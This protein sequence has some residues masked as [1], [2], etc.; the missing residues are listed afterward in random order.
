[1]SGRR[2]S[3]SAVAFTVL[4]VGVLLL[5]VMFAAR[6]GPH[7]IFAGP[8]RDPHFAPITVSISPRFGGGPAGRFHQGPI[9]HSAF[10]TAVGWVV[11]LAILAC[12]L[13]VGYRGVRRLLE[14]LHDLRHRQRLTPAPDPDF[15]VLD[16]PDA[17]VTEMRKDADE[18]FE[19]LLDGAPRNAIVACWDRFEEQAERTGQSRLEWETSSEF[20]LR[21]LDH[22]AADDAAVAQLERLY[23]EA[24]FSEHEIG[25]DQRLAAVEAL[26]RI[27]ASL[28]IGVRAR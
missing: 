22:V 1:M 7:R 9:H 3:V 8:L 11:R 18:Q 4:A 19:L 14:W 15:D 6:S 2:A 21:L 13:W 17:L 10:L 16:D 25:E 12:L 23:R 20:V 28:G 5:V 24:R 26:R 27:H